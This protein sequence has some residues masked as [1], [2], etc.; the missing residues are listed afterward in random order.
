MTWFEFLAWDS[1]SLGWI[2]VLFSL[3]TSRWFNSISVLIIIPWYIELCGNGNMGQRL[4][5][6]ISQKQTVEKEHRK[7][8]ITL[9]SCWVLCSFCLSASSVSTECDVHCCNGRDESF[10]EGMTCFSDFEIAD[11]YTRNPFVK[12][13][14]RL[15]DFMNWLTEYLLIRSYQKLQI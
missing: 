8:S 9:Y 2:K 5:H 15:R 13:P 10:V 3:I 1:M 4:K 6:L 14:Y 7:S 12:F 11:K